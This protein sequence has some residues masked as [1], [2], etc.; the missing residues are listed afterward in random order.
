LL[1][2]DIGEIKE[3][4]TAINW[5]KKK[6]RC[7]YKHGRM[8]DLMRQKIGEELVRPAVTRFATSY[9]TLASMYKHKNGL[10]L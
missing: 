7:L 10:E 3:F 2:Q 1:L 6:C 8:L 4:N 9:L 5:G